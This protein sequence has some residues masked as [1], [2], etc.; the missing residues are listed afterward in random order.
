[1][2][3]DG[4]TFKTPPYAHQLAMWKTT[5]DKREWAIFAEMGTGKSK[6]VID[7]AAWLWQQGRIDSL[8]IVAP[9]GG[10]HLWE[11]NEIPRHLPDSVPPAVGR[12]K[13][14]AGKRHTAHLEQLLLL[15]DKFLLPIAILN[16]E[17]FSVSAPKTSRALDWAHAFLDGRESM[18]VVDESTAIKRHNSQRTKQ[19]TAFGR[20]ASYRRILAGNP[21]AN[22]PLDLY[23]QLEFLQ[24]GYSGARSYFAFRGAYAHLRQMPFGPQGKL[25]QQVVGFKNQD[26]LQRMLAARTTIIKKEE[27]LDLPPKQYTTRLVDLTKQQS[28]YYKNLKEVG[29]LLL[30]NQSLV[31]APLVITQTLR[32]QQL[33][34][35]HLVTDEGETITIPN[36]PRD[37]VLLEV[38]Q[39]ATKAIVWV[40]FRPAVETV[41]EAIEKEFGKGSCVTYYGGTSTADR[42]RAEELFQE[43]ASPV[44]FFVATPQTAGRGLTLTAADTVVFY[45]NLYDAELREQAEDRA[46]R[47]GQTKSVTYVDLIAPNTVDEKI[48]EAL[49]SKQA[50]SEAI[51]PSNWRE[52]L[53]G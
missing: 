12:W 36:N 41:F 9:K 32:L 43:E 27:C 34:C 26:R 16:T 7:T 51:T 11:K 17:A 24:A 6:V 15:H 42:E 33:L 52:W 8:A 47:A 46:H 3:V 48:R 45:S 44:R 25:I 2:T 37:R 50:I 22:S 31:T 29:L 28:M 18:V 40:P 39:E 14:G 20:R 38:L 5:R 10:Y 23:G 30:E 35:G 13:A 49:L 4:Y 1:M 19:I 53:G 21:A